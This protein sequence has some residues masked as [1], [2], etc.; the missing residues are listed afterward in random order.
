MKMKRLMFTLIELLVVIAIIAILASMLLPALNKARDKA[1]SVS[2]VNNL[3]QLG[4][5]VCLY[6]SDY[7]GYYPGKTNGAGTFYTNLEPYSKISAADANKVGKSGI[8]LCPDDKYRIQLG[9]QLR[10]SYGQNYYM[11]WDNCYDGSQKPLMWRPGSMKRPSMSIYFVDS[12]YIQSGREG[13]PVMVSGNTWPFKTTASIEFG[14][15]F[16]HSNFANMLWGDCHVS[17][18]RMVALYGSGSNYL[19]TYN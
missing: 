6:Q 4:Q 3:K 19:T 5:F 15:D 10:N 13:W 11:R 1:K 8:Y 16:R 9:G 17:A 18:L 14:A 2:C 7:N 12:M